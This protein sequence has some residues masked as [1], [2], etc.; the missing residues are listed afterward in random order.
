MRHIAIVLAAV[1]C[2]VLATLLVIDVA[3]RVTLFGHLY[4]D[5]ASAPSAP[6]TIVLGAEVYA[7]GRPSPALQS[8]LDVAIE[9]LEHGKTNLLVMSG[10]NGMFEVDAM[11]AY[12][13]A[14]DVPEGGRASRSER[15]AHAGQLR[16]C[17]RHVSRATDPHRERH[18]SAARS[19]CTRTA[20]PHP[21]SP[22][23]ATSHT[24]SANALRSCWPSSNL[25]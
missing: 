19:A 5:A 22:G 25:S 16:A 14:H 8:R 13:V 24:S 7:D 4:A 3:V 23:I 2:V 12:L 10:G 15:R 1:A 18:T 6:V 20:W 17:A 21:S 11:R 9:L